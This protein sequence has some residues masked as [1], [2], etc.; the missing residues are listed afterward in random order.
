M[1]DERDLLKIKSKYILHFDEGIGSRYTSCV[2]IGISAS[3][4]V[5]YY[6]LAYRNEFNPINSIIVD[7]LRECDFILAEENIIKLRKKGHLDYSETKNYDSR[8]EDCRSSYQ[9]LEKI[10]DEVGI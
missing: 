2:C 9:K 5:R 4:G 7:S 3:K 10:L 6:N 1:T 8:M